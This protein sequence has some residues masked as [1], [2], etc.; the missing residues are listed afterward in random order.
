MLIFAVPALSTN[1]QNIY[2]RHFPP[3]YSLH[4]C[5]KVL[6]L[7]YRTAKSW[8]H[9]R[10]LR[11]LQYLLRFNYIQISPLIS[12][13]YAYMHTHT[14]VYI[15]MALN[16]VL[17]LSNLYVR[18]VSPLFF[19]HSSDLLKTP[20]QWSHRMFY[21]LDLADYSLR[22]KVRNLFFYSQYFL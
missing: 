17:F 6:T 22:N 10:Q 3:N 21:I 2:T 13:I 19:S 20:G 16:C 4:M 9:S 1:V 8:W 15:Y 12:Y 11:I 5:L 18:I 14:Y 7:S